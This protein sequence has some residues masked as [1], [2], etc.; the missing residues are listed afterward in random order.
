[1]PASAR[2]KQRPAL[3]RRPAGEVG[4]IPA[5]RS[6]QLARFTGR[7]LLVSYLIQATRCAAAGCRLCR[8]DAAAYRAALKIQA[9]QARTVPRGTFS[10]PLSEDSQ[11]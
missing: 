1:M 6:M 4:V 3:R 2:T 7:D 8:H 10:E 11:T 5:V 9:Q